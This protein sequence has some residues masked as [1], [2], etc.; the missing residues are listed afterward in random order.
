MLYNL[1]NIKS[2]DKEQ[3]V[4]LAKKDHLFIESLIEY[5][6][7]YNMFDDYYVRPESVE[8]CDLYMLHEII[9]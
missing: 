9:F 1:D 5:A 7:K 8:N 2:L 3:I 4:A 6:D